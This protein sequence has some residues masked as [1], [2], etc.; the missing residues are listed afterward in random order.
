MSGRNFG[1]FCNSNSKS[2]R[3]MRI[4]LGLTNQK[5]PTE[6]ENQ[7][8]EIDRNMGNSF[9]PNID[10]LG[11]FDDVWSGNTYNMFK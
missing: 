7:K 11:I 6:K 2:K 9:L 1:T 8:V 5:A 3:E 4:F 10:I